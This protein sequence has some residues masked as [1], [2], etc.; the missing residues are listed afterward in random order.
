MTPI[1]GRPII[2]YI[3]KYLKSTKIIK[4]IIIVADF[5]G[6]GGQIKNY[7]ENQKKDYFLCRILKEEQV[8]ICY[9]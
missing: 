1:N 7:L 8:E 4:E 3:V 6:L 9:I 2:D 5:E